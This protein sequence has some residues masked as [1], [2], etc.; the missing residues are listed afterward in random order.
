[1]KKIESK[2]I[3]LEMIPK[4][5]IFDLNKQ[6]THIKVIIDKL[7]KITDCEPLNT[8]CI[9]LGII[10]WAALCFYAGLKY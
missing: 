4:C 10:F 7:I 9:A 5:K 1:M 3:Y 2:L 8:I 6:V